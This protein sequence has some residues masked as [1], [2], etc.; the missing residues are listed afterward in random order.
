MHKSFD[1]E[2]AYRAR[3]F[4]RVVSALCAFCFPSVFFASLFRAHKSVQ[5][6]GGWDS[7]PKEIESENRPHK[8]YH[9][10][11]GLAEIGVLLRP[12]GQRVGGCIPVAFDRS[13]WE[14]PGKVREKTGA[15]QRN[16]K[17]NIASQLV[18]AS[19][20][21]AMPGHTR[22]RYGHEP[23]EIRVCAS[24][25][26]RC[27]AGDTASPGFAGLQRSS[28]AGAPWRVFSRVV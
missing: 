18:V 21:E 9:H 10:V 2:R 26:A 4:T 16:G 11:C 14:H 3:T 20:S 1:F 6:S 8:T 22:T 15:R 12:R 24:V 25:D 27:S 17:E 5:R 13:G 23:H 19:V 7:K 28:N